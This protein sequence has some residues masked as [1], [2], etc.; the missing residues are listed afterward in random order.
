V[1]EYQYLAVNK[2][3][4]ISNSMD[5]IIRKQVNVTLTGFGY[6]VMVICLVYWISWLFI[7]SIIF[8]SLVIILKYWE[9]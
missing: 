3:K 9:N 7:R 8:W 4:T 5:Y 1:K 2:T 6:G